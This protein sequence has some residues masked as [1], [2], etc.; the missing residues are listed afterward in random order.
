M[1]GDDGPT[2]SVQMNPLTEELKNRDSAVFSMDSIFSASNNNKDDEEVGGYKNVYSNTSSENLDTLV[3]AENPIHS[4]ASALT[5]QR[6]QLTAVVPPTEAVDD[7]AA[8]YLEYQNLQDSH[9]NTLYDMSNNED[10]EVAMTFEEWKATRKQFKQ[11]NTHTHLLAHSFTYSFT[12][13]GTRGSF[14]KAFQVFEEREKVALE[15]LE[16]SASVQNTMK[17]H[18]NKVKNILAA[19]RAF[20]VNRPK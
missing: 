10:N 2:I 8:L 3:T 19:T 13:S 14:V 7:D 9:D 1:K 17:L 18:S 5:A 15:S 12:Y 16:A 11:G 20:T 6:L 4:L